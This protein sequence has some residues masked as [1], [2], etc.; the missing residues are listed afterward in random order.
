MPRIRS[1]ERD[2]AKSLWLESGKTLA[3]TA[4]AAELDVPAA[5]VRKWKCL[6]KWDAE[7]RNGNGRKKGNGN[8]NEKKRKPG[9]QPGNRNAVGHLPS[10]P[11]GNTNALQTGAFSAS[12]ME[13]LPPAIRQALEQSPQD[14]KDLL[15]FKIA[16]SHGREYLILQRI[17][18]L[19]ATLAKPPEEHLIPDSATRKAIPLPSDNG[20][21][22]K[23]SVTDITTHSE[24]VDDR[25]LR[26]EAALTSIQAETRR[27]IE[28]LARI[29]QAE[30]SANR[31]AAVHDERDD[32]VAAIIEADERRRGR[33]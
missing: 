24:H 25:I 10:A 32:L 8:G 15:R 14:V 13:L 7:K 27:L 30:A 17:Q 19:R 18:E 4:I 16:L 21:R 3:L 1:P 2:K 20:D 12:F 29:E 11:V 6:D 5:Q 33:G 28:A 26:Y 22:R 9:G 31:E 23:V